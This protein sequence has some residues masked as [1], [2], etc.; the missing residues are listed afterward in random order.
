MHR[1]CHSRLQCSC[2]ALPVRMV[3][4]LRC[5]S[6]KRTRPS[7]CLLPFC[8]K[9]PG[10]QTRP[11]CLLATKIQQKC[12]PMAPLTCCWPPRHFIRQVSRCSWRIKVFLSMNSWKYIFMRIVRLFDSTSRQN[13]WSGI[14][15]RL[16]IMIS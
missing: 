15:V 16:K 2:T 14:L 4:Q 13:R 1:P 9:C 10:R 7:S 11:H 6:V 5:N 12:S 8:L 3:R